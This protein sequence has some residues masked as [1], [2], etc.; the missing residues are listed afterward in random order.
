[1]V[2]S[3]RLCFE[4]DHSA[5]ARRADVN[6]THMHTRS[7]LGVLPSTTQRVEHGPV[8]FV[9]FFQV[10]TTK[11]C[12]EYPP[13]LKKVQ[14][15]VRHT[16]FT[17]KRQNGWGRPFSASILLKLSNLGWDKKEF[18]NRS[19][20]HECRN[21]NRGRA[22]SFMEIFVSNFRYCLCSV[23]QFPDNRRVLS[24]LIRENF[25]QRSDY[26]VAYRPASSHRMET[27]LK[28]RRQFS[29]QSEPGLAQWSFFLTSRATG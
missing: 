16:E 2:S 21:W 3:R 12:E 13:Q 19:Q 1:M 24:F 17:W 10:W 28:K 6:N 22:V 23:G 27:P 11:G 4:P 18:T 14:T 15:E 7:F 9:A 8:I 25:H 20:N 29:S 5:F 26:A